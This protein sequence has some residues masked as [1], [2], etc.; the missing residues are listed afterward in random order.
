[1]VLDN[2]GVAFKTTKD[3]VKSLALKAKVNREQTIG[4]SDSQGESDEDVDE[5]EELKK[6][7]ENKV[8][9][10]GA[11]SD[12]ED[13][14]E[15]Q[16]DATCLVEIVTQEVVSKS[17][18]SNYDLNIIDLQKENEELLRFNKDFNKSFEKLLK[19]K[20][21]LENENSKLLSKINDLE[22]KAYDGGHVVF[23][24]N[25]KGKVVSG[26]NITHDSITITN[27]EHVSGLAVNLISVGYS[28][29]SKA[30]IVLNKEI[31]RIEE[32]LNVTFDESFPE[33]KSS[34][35]VEDDWI[36]K[37]VV[38]NPVRSLSLKAN[39]LEPGYP[40]NLKE[41]RGHTIEQVIGELDDRTV[42]SKTKQA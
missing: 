35:S 33:P 34:S 7:K 1:M 9:A 32:S 13:N 37:P 17:S 4:D 20:R 41:D 30:Y 27:V 36:I 2:D 11:W 31:M 6:P 16:N 19:E 12:S 15:P 38:Q 42:R 5:E 23:G 25:L 22:I 8:F 21:S 29:N 14:D 18:N 28:Q 10:G 24:S 40:K 3:K 26:C 39:P